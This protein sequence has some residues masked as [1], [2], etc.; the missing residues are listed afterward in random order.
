MHFRRVADPRGGRQLGKAGLSALGEL[1]VE[2]AL[3]AERVATDL[4]DLRAGDRGA[5]IL[6]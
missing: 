4:G 2:L 6:V 1:G 3:D 5:L